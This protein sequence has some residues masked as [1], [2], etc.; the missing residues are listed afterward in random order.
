MKVLRE[1]AGV[2]GS[3]LGGNLVF[4]ARTVKREVERERGQATVRLRGLRRLEKGVSGAK[5][6]GLLPAPTSL[7]EWNI[8][9]LT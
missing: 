7:A 4:E 9:M 1:G 2:N 6:G 8:K 5:S 3:E